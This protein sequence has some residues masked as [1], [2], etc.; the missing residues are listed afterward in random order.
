M[1]EMMKYI[2]YDH[3]TNSDKRKQDMKKSDIVN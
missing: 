1:I 2:Q 3:A